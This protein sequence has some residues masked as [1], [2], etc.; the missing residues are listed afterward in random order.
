V[1]DD[2]VPVRGDPDVE[3]HGGCPAVER[4]LERDQRVFGALGRSA[5][6]RHDERKQSLTEWSFRHYLRA[7]V[8]GLAI[9]A[10]DGAL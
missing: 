7:Y 8:D 4:S 9:S 1:D 10:G 5:P 6:V 3:L 2:R